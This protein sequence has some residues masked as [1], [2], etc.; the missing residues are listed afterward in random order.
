[1]T[2]NK[3]KPTRLV[4]HIPLQAI[5]TISLTFQ[6]QEHT[7][8][9]CPPEVFDEFVSQYTEVEE[10]NRKLWSSFQR[11]RVINF[12][13]DDGALE[14]AG[15]KLVELPEVELVAQEGA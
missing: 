5:R 12:L 7:I 11:W 9:D 14:V 13:I 6:E 2:N 4:D 1:M 10:V 3:E 8:L 15:G